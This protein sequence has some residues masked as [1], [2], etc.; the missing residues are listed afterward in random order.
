MLTRLNRKGVPFCSNSVRFVH[1]SNASPAYDLIPDIKWA[2]H[3]LK[4]K[5]PDLS[6]KQIAEQLGIRDDEVASVLSPLPR[7]FRYPEFPEKL[8]KPHVQL[9]ES[10]AAVGVRRTKFV[11]SE[12]GKGANNSNR[13][14]S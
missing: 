13:R 5:K 14:V 8:R 6:T 10:E 2:I 9:S 3:Y 12:V 11:F 1:S 7:V 4:F